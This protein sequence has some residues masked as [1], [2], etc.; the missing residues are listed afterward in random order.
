MSLFFSIAKK[1]GLLILVFWCVLF[2]AQKI[3]LPVADLGRH[4]QNGSVIIHGSNAD[5]HGV[6][7]TNF[8]SYTEPEHN[9]VNHH[10][11]S[12]VVFYLVHQAWG[13]EGL[14]LFYILLVSLAF[15]F[16]LKTAENVSNWTMALGVGV[17]ILPII[18]QR[19]E[20]RPEAFT[21]LFLAVF[22]F[23]LTLN[24][25]GF[26]ESSADTKAKRNVSKILWLLPVIMLL[27]VNLH[28][29]FIF[30]F[31][32]LGTFM[33]IRAIEELRL[34]LKDK[35]Y[36]ISSQLKYLIGVFIGSL[37]AGLLN[38]FGIHGL[39]YP[40]NIFRE[41]GYR[42]VENQTVS[43]LENLGITHN[44]NFGLLKFLVLFT[45]LS[46]IGLGIKQKFNKSF[47]VE[48]A[49]KFFLFLTI[50]T[51]AFLAVRN[52]PIF[53]ILILPLLAQNLY[54]L[55]PSSEHPAYKIFPSVLV[56]CMIFFSSLL[57]GQKFQ[58]QSSN[59]G[60]GLLPKVEASAE[61]FKNHNL[62]GPIFNNYDVGGYLI[63]ELGQADKRGLK[64]EDAGGF[65]RSI[66]SNYG[67]VFTDN[68]PEAYSL[69]HFQQEYIPAQEDDAK[70]QA[71]MQ[72]YQFNVIF[73]SRRDLTPW[74]QNFLVA[75]VKDALW[76]PVFVDSY[77][78]ILLK[79]DNP[80]NSE[81]IK[82]YELPKSMFGLST[83]Y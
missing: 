74:G 65:D 50:S 43:F 46:F 5:R 3:D 34:K 54:L 60:I 11:L 72:K 20:I 6:L 1:L 27:W 2:L 61:F 33:L 62:T 41:Y 55:L 80:A 30:G 18:T 19:V 53:G 47:G 78:I 49:I 17:L 58:N 12:G 83:K 68:R 67:R 73:F 32:I 70:W 75:R 26:G 37:V 29:G 4:I 64:P 44:M 69:A 25:W 38:P 7:Y 71:L 9:F 35:N 8:Y 56:A 51:L 63:Y 36:Q 82:K 76:A 81:I 48:T 13:F 24:R 10:W 77:N 21:Y 57:F 31:L 59:F 39:L 42:I 28:I 22:N 14:S 52:F 66:S 16:C 45:A 15:M 23:C 40:L 79:R